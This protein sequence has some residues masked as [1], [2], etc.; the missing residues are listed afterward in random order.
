MSTDWTAG[1][2]ELGHLFV[3]NTRKRWKP[4]NRFDGTYGLR[5]SK[6]FTVPC[7]VLAIWGDTGNPGPAEALR[8]T[9]SVL[10]GMRA[11]KLH[12]PLVQSQW[13][14]ARH[15]AYIDLIELEHALRAAYLD[16]TELPKAPQ[17]YAALFQAA[18]DRQRTEANAPPLKDLDEVAAAIRDSENP[19]SALLREFRWA[20]AAFEGE[21]YL[22][23]AV[24]PNEYDA[25]REVFDGEGKYVGCV[26]TGDPESPNTYYIHDAYSF[27]HPHGTTRRGDRQAGRWF[28]MFAGLA[29]THLPVESRDKIP[30]PAGDS[31]SWW[32]RFMFLNLPDSQEDFERD[33][34]ILKSARLVS[35]SPF[36][37]SADAIERADLIG[38][39]AKAHDSASK[40]IDARPNQKGYVGQPADPDAYVSDSELRREHTP[41]GLVLSP[42]QLTG[43]LED[44]L[45][46][47]IRWTRPLTKQGKPNPHRRCVHLGD[48]RR[49]IDR[50]TN[51]A[52]SGFDGGA[53]PTPDEIAEAKAEIRN[54]S[55]CK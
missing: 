29:G 37:D 5:R 47:R 12:V 34:D 6:D 15:R 21:S 45:T 48:W 30:H 26:Q 49:F 17:K 35:G 33:R 24:T 32:L 14:D 22:L 3:I 16:S 44:H 8:L 40:D 9:E 54:R 38:L 27:L 10:E 13:G 46:N 52:A 2:L 39:Y 20:A 53:D 18:I 42:K 11:A 1:L 23:S 19:F 51:P 43:I 55:R 25:H 28:R 4:K 41:E 50:Q 31:V 36:A 7:W